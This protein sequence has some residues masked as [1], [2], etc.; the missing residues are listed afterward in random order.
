[1]VVSLSALC[2]GRFYPSKQSWYLFLLEAESTPGHSAIGRILCPWKIPMTPTGIE[3][4][5]FRY[6]AQHFNYRATAVPNSRFNYAFVRTD[7]ITVCRF[8]SKKEQLFPHSKDWQVVIVVMEC[9]VC[10]EQLQSLNTIQ[11]TFCLQWD[12]GFNIS[13]LSR[14]RWH[15]IQHNKWVT[16]KC[17]AGLTY[18]C[19]QELL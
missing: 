8:T 5:T 16:I 17:I 9:I 3:P 11:V 6:V 14:L 1:M 2:I 4:A 15:K 7:C 10:V 19:H 13:I 12:K 18:G